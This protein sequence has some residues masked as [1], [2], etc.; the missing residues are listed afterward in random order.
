MTGKLKSNTVLDGRTLTW[1]DL[2]TYAREVFRVQGR[3]FVPGFTLYGLMM[4]LWQFDRSG[5]LGSFCFDINEDEFRFVHLI[6]GYF[7][8]NDK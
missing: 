7:L 5:S 6:L 3:R 4:R 1:L 2:A 8:M